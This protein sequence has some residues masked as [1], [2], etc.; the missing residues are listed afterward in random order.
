MC[1]KTRLCLCLSLSFFTLDF[2]LSTITQSLLSLSEPL[3]LSSCRWLIVCGFT[4]AAVANAAVCA[5]MMAGVVLLSLLREPF[6]PSFPPLGEKLGTSL[7]RVL[8]EIKSL[9]GVAALAA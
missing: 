4:T 6:N 5:S 9:L 3:S 8:D 7:E 1:L 2:L